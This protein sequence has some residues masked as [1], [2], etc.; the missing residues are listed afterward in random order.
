[1]AKTIAPAQ[2]ERDTGDQ[3]IELPK[4]PTVLEGSTLEGSMAPKEEVSLVEVKKRRAGLLQSLGKL[5]PLLPVLSS[6]LRMVD[7]GAVQALAHLLNLAEGPGGAST[8]AHEE[9]QHGLAE[10]ESNHHAL[11]LQVQAQTVEVQRL[12]DQITLLR[13]TVERDASRHEELAEKVRSLS[14]LVRVVSAGLGILLV[15]LITLAVL[16]LTR[17][18]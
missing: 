5:K 12:E 16:V 4:K 14:N 1:M 9:L 3:L 15:I 7:H 17:H 10:I 2:T 13:E 8:A 6:G 18:P 11:H